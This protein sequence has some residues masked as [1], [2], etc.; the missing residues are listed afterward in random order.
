MNKSYQKWSVPMKRS[1]QQSKYVLLK[2]VHQQMYR[3]HHLCSIRVIMR[4]LAKEWQCC[5]TMDKSKMLQ[6]MAVVVTMPLFN[7]YRGWNSSTRVSGSVNFSGTSLV[8]FKST[9]GNLPVQTVVNV[10]MNILGE[11]Q[12]K[13]AFKKAWNPMV[14][15]E[16]FMT[17]K[18][19]SGIRD[20]NTN[21]SKCVLQVYW[22][23]ATYL[24]PVIA[25]ICKIP[26]LVLYDIHMPSDGTWYFKHMSIVMI[27]RIAVYL[28]R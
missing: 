6:G 13:L 1:N 28:V 8:T 10:C 22:M 11:N 2:I 27:L 20:R 24:L 14:H 4:P 3:P 18:V 16:R 12:A 17:T 25:H 26:R 19:M 21:F 5:N 9:C 23:D 7:S 15:Q